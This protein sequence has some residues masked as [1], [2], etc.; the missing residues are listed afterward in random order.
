VRGWPDDMRGRC[1]GGR[2][3]A[4]AV[5][6]GGMWGI[7]DQGP[8]PGWPSCRHKNTRYMS[9][10]NTDGCQNGLALAA[11]QILFEDR[12]VFLVETISFV[13]VEV[14]VA[15]L[16]DLGSTVGVLRLGIAR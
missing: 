8:L 11:L 12:S 5:T 4:G 3:L 2:C 13:L 16:L 9:G 10:V 15:D 14:G 6:L 7:C 1:R